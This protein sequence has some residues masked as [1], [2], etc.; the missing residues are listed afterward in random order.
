MEQLF[1]AWRF[2]NF[3]KNTETIDTYVTHVRQVA[4]L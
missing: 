2:F 4:A 1:H 3:D